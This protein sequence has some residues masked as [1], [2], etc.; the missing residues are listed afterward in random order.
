MQGYI[1]EAFYTGRLES[2][3][4]VIVSNSAKC[5]NDGVITIIAAQQ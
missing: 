1:E 5:D 2:A 4:Y 3:K